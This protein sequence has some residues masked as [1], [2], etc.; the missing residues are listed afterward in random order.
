M[1]E[2]DRLADGMKA[3]WQTIEE[4]LDRRQQRLCRFAEKLTLTPAEM[5]PQ[6]L[7]ELREVGLSD[8]AIVEAVHVIGYFNHINRVADALGVDL[9]DFMSPD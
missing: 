9:E 6:D 1:S 8:E 4:H 7:D 3:G 5:R 2:D